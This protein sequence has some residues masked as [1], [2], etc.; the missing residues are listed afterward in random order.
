[1]FTKAG[2]W[3]LPRLA[4]LGLL[5]QDRLATI[6]ICPEQQVPCRPRPEPDNHSRPPQELVRSTVC[7]HGFL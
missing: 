7:K 3:V 6:S 5:L 2:Q 1:M 4:M